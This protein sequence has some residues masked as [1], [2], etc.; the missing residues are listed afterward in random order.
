MNSKILDSFGGKIG[1]QWVANL[2]TPAFAFWLGGGLVTI[3][4][5]GWQELFK[6]SSSY[7]QLL[8]VAISVIGLCALTISAFVVRRLDF[9][10]L[11][12]LEGYW[13]PWLSFL[14][15][16]CITLQQRRYDK[17]DQTRNRLRQKQDDQREKLKAL[18]EIICNED[19]SAL[20][21]WQK[22]EFRQLNQQLLS[23]SDQ[24]RLSQILI[25]QSD[26]PYQKV[27]FMPTRLGNIL[28]AAEHKPLNKYG[29]DAVICWPRLWMLLPD[30]V[31]KDLQESRTDLNT[32]VNIW[33]W[34]IL[35]CG[36]TIFAVTPN[37]INIQELWP[38]FIGILTAYLAY[39]WALMTGK[40]YGE[41]IEASFDLYRQLLYQIL[42]F[43]VPVNLVQE[44][45]SGKQL[46]HYLR[47]GQLN[48]RSI[49]SIIASSTEE[50]RKQMFNL[51][52]QSSAMVQ[53][54]IYQAT[55]EGV[56]Q[57][58]SQRTKNDFLVTLD[59]IGKEAQ[60]KGLTEEIL[61]GLLA[62]ES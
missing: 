15:Q 19:A 32:A 13:H 52:Q 42:R 59:Q 62:D 57:L 26:M 10:V 11:R 5:F 4:H 50:S 9:I 61:A 49:S 39:S 20:T 29:L 27:D 36:W 53:N 41:Q 23:F 34:G 33:S 37:G 2:L 58:S 51:P 24:Q 31:K 30:G 55:E 38:L 44:K 35:F 22:Q 18:N 46:T 21:D 47:T 54:K 28:R 7:P 17:S 56:R 8:Q 25:Y 16:W 45:E 14:Q 6:V 1:E 48:R 12:F 40:I 60:D 3:Q 43:D